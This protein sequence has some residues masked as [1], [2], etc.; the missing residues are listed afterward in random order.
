MSTLSNPFRVWA[1]LARG[2]RERFIK[3]LGDPPYPQS[4]SEILTAIASI[5][6]RCDSLSASL[7]RLN[8]SSPDAYEAFLRALEKS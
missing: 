3:E 5:A 8:T 6:M 7:K 2:L 4:A 1:E